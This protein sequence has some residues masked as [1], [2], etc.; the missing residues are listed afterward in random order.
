MLYFFKISIK[1]F[2]ARH[3]FKDLRSKYT[4]KFVYISMQYDW[5]F[6]PISTKIFMCLQFI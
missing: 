2:L 3:L 5:Y 1:Q 6:C 4:L